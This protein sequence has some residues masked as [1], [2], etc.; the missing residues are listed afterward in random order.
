M[1]NKEEMMGFLQ[2]CRVDQVAAYV[3]G[4]Q[5]YSNLPLDVLEEKWVAAFRAMA[6]NPSDD[7]LRA[8]HTEY[9]CEFELRGLGPPYDLV[10]E[11]MEAVRV[12]ATAAIEFIMKNE[13]ERFDEINKEIE[14]DLAKFREKI[15]NRS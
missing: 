11:E 13:P 1:T 6:A 12:A 14:T 15:R 5:R 7:E 8:H 4:G 9:D 3:K 10:S 2:S